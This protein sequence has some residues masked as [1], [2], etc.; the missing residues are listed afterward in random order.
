MLPGEDI[1]AILLSERLA[2][3]AFIAGV[4]RDF[5]LAEDIFQE[6]CVKAVAR[7]GE[8]ESAQHVMNWARVAGRN[9]A[10]DVLRARDGRYEGLSEELLATL[11]AEWPGK[12]HAAAAHD[13]LAHCLEHLTPNN[14]ELLRLRY[15]E[16]RS[17]AEVAEVLGRK[18]ETI[19]Q[20][21]ARIHKSLADCVR[22]RLQ[23]EAS[24]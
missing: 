14:R 22:R 17:G 11:A 19:Y 7:G 1:A 12:E 3:T 8:F 23:L 10:I 6:V 4:T 24:S 13:A 5:H 20:A 15:F 21:L 16:R 2:L 18:L 9:R